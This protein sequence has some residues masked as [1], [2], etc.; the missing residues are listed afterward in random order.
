MNTLDKRIPPKTGQ[1]YS[2]LIHI[3]SQRL[4]TEFFFKTYTSYIYEKGLSG[5]FMAFSRML[6]VSVSTDVE[7]PKAFCFCSNINFLS[8]A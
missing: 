8:A 5:N 2:S 6:W 3:C 1:T 7:R 4:N